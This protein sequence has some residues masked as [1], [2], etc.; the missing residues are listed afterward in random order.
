MYMQHTCKRLS[1]RL[2]HGIQSQWR[3]PHHWLPWL[4]SSLVLVSYIT[5]SLCKLHAMHMQCAE[6]KAH[7]WCIQTMKALLDRWKTCKKTYRITC[8]WINNCF[9]SSS[10]I[11]RWRGA[12]GDSA[13]EVS[14]C[15]SRRDGHSALHRDF[16][17]PHGAHQVVQGNWARSG[18]HLQSKRSSF[19]Q[20]NKCCRCHKEKQ[21]GLFHP[22][23]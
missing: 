10:R 20:S 22:H 2:D 6:F 17:E 23:Q 21:H 8:G 9:V 5:G 19:P 14:V 4:S 15:C 11:G 1:S 12:A 13:W 3:L 16:P 7:S 18:V